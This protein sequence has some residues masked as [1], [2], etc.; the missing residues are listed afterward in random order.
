MSPYHAFNALTYSDSV[1]QVLKNEGLDICENTLWIKFERAEALEHERRFEEA[2]S[3]YFDIILAAE[4]EKWWKLLANAHISLARTFEA[5]DRLPECLRNLNEAKLVIE[6]HDLGQENARYFKRYASYLRFIN[7]LDSS[8]YFAY[9][10]VEYGEKF[11]ISRPITDGYLLL[12]VAANNLD[13]TIYFFKKSRD[14]FLDYDEYHGATS[15]SLNIASKLFKANRLNEGWQELDRAEVL[16]SKMVIKTKGYYDMKTAAFEIRSRVYEKQGKTDSALHYLKLSVEN[17]DLANYELDQQKINSN[18]INFVLEKEKTKNLN[19][20]SKLLKL[21]LILSLL[22]ILIFSYLWRKNK[23][24]N[25]QLTSQH[26][27]ILTQKEKLE[28]SLNKQLLLLSEVHHRVKNNLQLVISLLALKTRNTKN[29]EI[30]E[31]LEN[32]SGKI[33]GI[34]LIHE[35]L[36]STEEFENVDLELYF[37]NLINQFK[38]ITNETDFEITCFINDIYLN[39]E[40][41][42]PLGMIFTELLSN[43]LKHGK[44]QGQKLII[45]INFQKKENKYLMNYFDNGPGMKEDYPYKGLGLNLLKN[46]VRQLQAESRFFNRN[47]THFNLLFEEKH[48]SKI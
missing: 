40:T 37:N 9:K 14:A 3:I 17:K 48:I 26:N 5:I 43:S 27:I 15:L 38:S 33:N 4:K 8:K 30:K 10:A 7:Q 12:G 31:Y 46:M 16:L 11:K 41:V 6:K 23:L 22:S 42:M 28:N 29:T 45:K 1:L 18:T 19:T 36:Y 39:L 32:I 44:I 35:Q 13:S 24:K 25:N 21:G 47:G 20:I 34:A 2:L